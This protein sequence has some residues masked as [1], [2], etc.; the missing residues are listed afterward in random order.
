MSF[1]SSSSVNEPACL[2]FTTV[3]DDYIEDTEEFVFLPT[4]ENALDVFS[5][6]SS[7]FTLLTFDDD[8]IA[9]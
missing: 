5:Q 2:V 7:N 8:G 9:T 3:D 6:S 1:D 4:T